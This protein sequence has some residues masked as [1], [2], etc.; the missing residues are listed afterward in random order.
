ME[1]SASRT[2]S[3]PKHIATEVQPFIGL[4]W[5]V[6]VLGLFHG[7]C[8]QQRLPGDRVDLLLEVGLCPVIPC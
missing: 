6:R 4:A 5:P 8:E 1:V 7:N 3:V 2:Q